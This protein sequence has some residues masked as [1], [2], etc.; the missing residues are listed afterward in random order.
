VNVYVLGGKFRDWSNEAHLQFTAGFSHID[1]KFKYLTPLS[2]S[3]FFSFSNPITLSLSEATAHQEP[4]M[5]STAFTYN[6]PEAAPQVLLAANLNNEA[7]MLEM[8]GNYAGAEKKHLEAIAL[9]VAAVGQDSIQ[10]ALSRNALGELY[11]KMNRL[12]DAQQMLE[13]AD[14]VRRSKSISLYTFGK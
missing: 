5:S 11:L 8:S 10:A 6:N 12:N 4:I 3:A 7:N 13:D 14:R 2:S 9:K 1:L